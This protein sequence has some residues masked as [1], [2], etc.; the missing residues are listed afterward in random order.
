MDLFLGIVA[1]LIVGAWLSSRI[2]RAAR[3]DATAGNELYQLAELIDNYFG[4]SAQPADL[5]GHEAFRNGVKLLKG[6]RYR[7]EHL[8]AYFNG[9]N[10]AIACMAMEALS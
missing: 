6:N 7:T 2:S 4:R 10:P 1:G 8:I 3:T 9:D 5:L